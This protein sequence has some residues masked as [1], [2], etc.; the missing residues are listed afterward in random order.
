LQTPI[1]NDVSNV[2]LGRIT[3]LNIID[4]EP[5]VDIKTSYDSSTTNGALL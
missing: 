3:P 2:N 4:V 5:T 1:P